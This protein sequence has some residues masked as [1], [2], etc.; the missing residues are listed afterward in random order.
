MT[1]I[2]ALPVYKIESQSKMDYIAQLWMRRPLSSPNPD[3]DPNTAMFDFSNLPSSQQAIRHLLKYKR[4]YLAAVCMCLVALTCSL[5]CIHPSYPLLAKQS[6][7]LGLQLYSREHP[8]PASTWHAC[9]D[10]RGGRHIIRSLPKPSTSSFP[11]IQWSSWF[12]GWFINTEKCVS[13]TTAQWSAGRIFHS[14]VCSRYIVSSSLRD[15]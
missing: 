12:F 7:T 13:Y 6:L 4:L 3:C 15:D 5:M 11:A 14:H 10:P 9:M 2:I 8:H 1:H